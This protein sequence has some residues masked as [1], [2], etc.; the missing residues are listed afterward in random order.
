MTLGIAH[1]AEPREAIDYVECRGQCSYPRVERTSKART[2]RFR[3]SSCGSGEFRLHATRHFRDVSQE[4]LVHWISFSREAAETG[5]KL[6]RAFMSV[7]A[8]DSRLARESRSALEAVGIEV[9]SPENLKPGL[10]RRI[11]LRNDIESSDAMIVISPETASMA[12]DN[13]VAIAM[14]G[15]KPVIPVSCAFRENETPRQSSRVQERR[16]KDVC[17]IATALR[18]RQEE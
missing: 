13:E 12:I 2:S 7:A 15:R 9:V 16:I 6:P 11:A 10:P 1:R 3:S 18:M 14:E 4:K 5:G 8:S 17:E